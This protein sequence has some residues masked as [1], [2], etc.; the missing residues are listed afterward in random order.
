MAEKEKTDFACEKCG[1][2]LERRHWG[3]AED[4]TTYQD[5]LTCVDSQCNYSKLV[6]CIHKNLNQEKEEKKKEG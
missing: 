1:A 5:L 4:L 2:Q 6:R 3:V